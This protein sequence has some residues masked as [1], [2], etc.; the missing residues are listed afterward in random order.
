MDVM[1]AIIKRRSI[2]RFKPDPIPDEVLAELVNGARLSPTGA[3]F[4]PLKFLVVRHP[5]RLAEV[6]TAL[7]WAAYV[8]PKRNPPDGHRPMGY[9]IILQDTRLKSYDVGMD[10]GLAAAAISF[11]AGKFGLGTCLIASADRDRLKEILNLPEYLTSKLVVALGAP[12]EDPV[13][14][15]MAAG[16]EDV[17]YWLDDEDRLHVPKRRLD[18]VMIIDQPGA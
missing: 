1:D 3:N 6:F 15:E 18:E 12:D 5:D 17:R 8:T 7:R 11:G 2:R 14:E 16:A 9:I 13:A 10:V 4:Q